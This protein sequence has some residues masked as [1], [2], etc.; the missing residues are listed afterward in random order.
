M[1]SLL[2]FIP[3]LLLAA[4]SENALGPSEPDLVTPSAFKARETGEGRA[5]GPG[6]GA[7]TKVNASWECALKAGALA[8]TGGML[9][10]TFPANITGATMVPWTMGAY[11]WGQQARDYNETPDCRSCYDDNSSGTIGPTNPWNMPGGS[12]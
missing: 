2:R 11:G 6:G 12:Q 5:V 1:R 9:V 10:G 7:C 8:I 3:L 4:C